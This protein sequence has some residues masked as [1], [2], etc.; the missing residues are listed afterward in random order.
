MADQWL[1]KGTAELV[2]GPG[3]AW[4]RPWMTAAVLSGWQSLPGRKGREHK[5]HVPEVQRA[6]GV[7][8]KGLGRGGKDSCL[9]GHSPCAWHRHHLSSM[10][11]S[12]TDSP[13]LKPQASPWPRVWHTQNCCKSVP[14]CQSGHSSA[15]SAAACAV[16]SS[17]LLKER[18]KAQPRQK[19]AT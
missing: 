8:L 11:S 14:E 18:E 15:T 13:S 9:Q 7:G 19:H 10:S 12:C 17:L 2:S 4:V 1:R 16:T 6:P 5:G 3:L